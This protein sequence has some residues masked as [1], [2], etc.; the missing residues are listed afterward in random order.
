MR[1]RAMGAGGVGPHVAARHAGGKLL[2]SMADDLPAGGPRQIDGTSGIVAGLTG[3]R[4]V[5]ADR[6]LADPLA[7]LAD[8]PPLRAAARGGDFWYS[9]P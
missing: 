9:A 7:P 8:Q 2:A 6:R 1:N 4:A 3:R 5:A